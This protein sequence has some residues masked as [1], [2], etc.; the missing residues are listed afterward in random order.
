MAL[1]TEVLLQLNTLALAHRKASTLLISSQCGSF[2]SADS[3]TWLK[4]ITGHTAGAPLIVVPAAGTAN[5]VSGQNGLDILLL[6][7]ILVLSVGRVHNVIFLFSKYRRESL[8]EEAAGRGRR[9][10][11]AFGRQSPHLFSGGDQLCCH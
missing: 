6:T 10:D 7:K 1:P 11:D 9:L 5:V 2:P 8:T 4:N 3:G